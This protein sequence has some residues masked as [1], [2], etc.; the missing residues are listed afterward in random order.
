MAHSTPQAGGGPETGGVGITG[1]GG[2]ATPC[3]TEVKGVGGVGGVVGAGAGPVKK[4]Q[5]QVLNDE[6]R[7][8]ISQRRCANLYRKSVLYSE[9]CY[10]N[11]QTAAARFFLQDL[12]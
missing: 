6:I 12:H 8:G 7:Q 2:T 1:T 4:V 11:G 9:A 3:A 5:Y 10:Q